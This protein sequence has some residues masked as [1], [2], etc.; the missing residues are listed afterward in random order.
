MTV[1]K[2]S[3]ALTPSTAPHMHPSIWPSRSTAEN[4]SSK[5]VVHPHHGALFCPQQVPASRVDRSLPSVYPALLRAHYALCLLGTVI[6]RN[7]F[8]SSVW[9]CEYN[10]VNVCDHCVSLYLSTCQPNNALMLSSLD[11]AYG[12][13]TSWAHPSVPSLQGSQLWA[14][15]VLSPK[16]PHKRREVSLEKPPGPPLA[17][18]LNETAKAHPEW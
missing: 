1:P 11:W 7:I 15:P 4:L 9:K 10:S 3:T 13:F 2:C 12:S 6:R 16:I 14:M 8:L 17:G 18:V 5:F